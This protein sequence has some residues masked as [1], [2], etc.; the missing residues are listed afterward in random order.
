[1]NKIIQMCVSNSYFRYTALIAIGLALIVTGISSG[2][3]SSRAV[4]ASPVE[5]NVAVQVDNVEET[6]PVSEPAVPSYLDNPTEMNVV[7]LSGEFDNGGYW[8]WDD[9]ANLLGIYSSYNAY[10]TATVE[11]VTYEGVP[12][13]YLLNYARLTTQANALVFTTHNGEQ[14]SYTANQTGDFMGYLVAL[15]A[16]G[17]LLLVLPYGQEPGVVQGLMRLEARQQA[18]SSAA[19]P[20]STDPQTVALV[21]GFQYDGNWSWEHI[22]NL[23]GVYGS[24]N[25]YR[26]VSIRS[27]EH[28]GVPVQY[29]LDYAQLT[30]PRAN[31]VLFHSRSGGRSSST[32][33]T[34]ADCL[35]CIIE[36]ADDGTLT[37]V[38]PGHSPEIMPLLAAIEVH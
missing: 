24:Y 23:L 4:A 17:E 8:S 3:G 37:L 7:V 13:T 29:L 22:A 33:A 9:I 5:A 20:V 2:S 12:L 28:R 31:A 18:D 1:M 14:Y 34:L 27:E 38:L 32:I 11:G 6:A 35:D 21:G 25:N 19:V 16:D 36:L 10:A 30:N 26:R 15:S